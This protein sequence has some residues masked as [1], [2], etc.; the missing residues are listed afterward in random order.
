MIIKSSLNEGIIVTGYRSYTMLLD[1]LKQIV[2][3]LEKT[4]PHINEKAYQN[5]WGYI[6]PR[7]A[8]ELRNLL[9]KE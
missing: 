5:Y 1:S 6:I 2:P 8:E 9:A 4:N 3:H 7:E